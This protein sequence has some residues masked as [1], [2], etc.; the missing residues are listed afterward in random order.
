MTRPRRCSAP[1]R[2]VSRV[3]P[4]LHDLLAT[5]THQWGNSLLG[6]AGRRRP[7]TIQQRRRPDRWVFV[8]ALIDS[9]GSPMRA[10]AEVVSCRRMG[11]S[12]D[13]PMSPVA[14]GA[15]SDSPDR[16]DARLTRLGRSGR[17]RPTWVGPCRLEVELARGHDV[18]PTT[19]I[20]PRDLRTGRPHR[21]GCRDQPTRVYDARSPRIAYIRDLRRGRG[22]D[23][24]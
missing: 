9:F 18:R 2:P 4:E 1:D 5:V 21:E 6:P 8:F 16:K 7:G 19:S 15:S 13:G 23:E 12:S 20:D 24:A 3:F 11:G 22:E 10:F 17:R 14:A